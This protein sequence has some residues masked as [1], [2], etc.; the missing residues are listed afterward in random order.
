[1][2]RDMPGG[3]RTVEVPIEALAAVKG[4][5]ALYF[6]F[7]SPVKNRSICTLHS[8]RFRE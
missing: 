7:S 2:A 4:R 5:E 3:L 8:L 1:V 6:T